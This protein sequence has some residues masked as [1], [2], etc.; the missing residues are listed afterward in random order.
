MDALEQT[1]QGAKIRVVGVG[2]AG[3]N[4]INT[5]IAAGLDRVQFIAANTDIQALAASN[6]QVKVQIGS[7][8][9][10]GLGAGANPDI[11]REAALESKELIAQALEGADMVFVTAGM[12]GGTGT[13]AAPIIA[14]IAKSLGALTV[15]V[16]TKPFHFEGNKRRKQADAGLVELKTAVDTL[17]TIPN[18]RLLTLGGQTMPLLDTFKRADEVLLNAVQGISDLIQYHGYINVD[19]ADV[20]TIMSDKGLAL[21]G[22]GRAAGEKRAVTAMQQAIASPLLED[23]TIDGATGLLINITGGRDLTLQEVNEALTLVHDAADEEAEIIF[24]SLIDDEVHEEVKITIIATGFLARDAR[25]PMA[26]VPGGA[27]R[28]SAAELPVATSV[29]VRAEARPAARPARDPSLPVDEDQ[30][31]IPTFLRRQGQNDPP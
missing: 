31:D 17:I 9:T 24:G 26:A 27:T 2:G 15:A 21:M 19:F 29:R 8:L 25:R 20:K 7:G 13:G 22:T 6:A 10:K 30:F 16:V 4:A 23:V 12:G 5:M 1:K 3:C 14:D 11:G 28:P 18:Q